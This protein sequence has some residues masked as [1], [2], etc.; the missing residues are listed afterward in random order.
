MF[1]R[2]I[3]ATR[4]DNN[5]VKREVDKREGSKTNVGGPRAAM[6]DPDGMARFFTGSDSE[7]DRVD[8]DQVRAALR[9]NDPGQAD[10]NT[11]HVVTHWDKFLNRTFAT[12][13]QVQLQKFHRVIFGS[14]AT[15]G[16]ALVRG[17]VFIEGFPGFDRMSVYYSHLPDEVQEPGAATVSM[18]QRMVAPPVGPVQMDAILALM[19][20]DVL[21]PNA[22]TTLVKNCLD[23]EYALQPSLGATAHALLRSVCNSGTDPQPTMI[24]AMQ[25]QLIM[26]GLPSTSRYA[27]MDI[28]GAKPA[29]VYRVWL[30]M[31]NMPAQ[32]VAHA[33][34]EVLDNWLRTSMSEYVAGRAALPSDALLH[35]G[36]IVNNV[37]STDQLKLYFNVV[38][39]SLTPNSKNRSVINPNGMI[40]P[41]DGA[42]FSIVFDCVLS[43][44][45]PA[46]PKLADLATKARIPSR[47]S[48]A[49]TMNVII[50][51]LMKLN[52]EKTDTNFAK[53]IHQYL[54]QHAKIP[55]DY[56]LFAD[57]RDEDY[58]PGAAVD[59]LW[60]L[61]NVVL[62]F[63]G[64]FAVD[65]A[66]TLRG[67]RKRA[68]GHQT[69][70][71]QSATPLPIQTNQ[72][73]LGFVVRKPNRQ[74]DPDEARKA[75]E[76]TPLSKRAR[77]NGPSGPSGGV[78]TPADDRAPPSEAP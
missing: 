37:P 53:I 40:F 41:P 22:L 16:E 42:R 71:P 58:A 4:N 10:L 66:K 63:P 47:N 52:T 67:V 38:A 26:A 57:L 51:S 77:T 72:T 27:A 5:V 60:R 18:T 2:K 45:R 74:D 28:A 12:G 65:D 64:R 75:L 19:S 70:I 68:R 62:E 39:S 1:G 54:I 29:F 43:A 78:R 7:D 48:M 73:T 24:S 46:D 31:L 61:F 25:R 56:P 30:L 8:E 36:F 23:A 44:Y 34:T 76:H 6:A 55:P 11:I 9:A 35:P 69:V 3:V 21:V 59:N 13:T 49:G 32:W 20:V 15:D 50:T 33:A 17:N 14:S